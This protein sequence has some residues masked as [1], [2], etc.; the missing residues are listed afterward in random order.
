MRSRPVAG[1]RAGVFSCPQ[2][3]VSRLYCP[4]NLA[5]LP[6]GYSVS[7]SHT[8]SSPT[9]RPHR[10]A[11][12]GG[13]DFSLDP[14]LVAVAV[15]GGQVGR[16][17]RCRSPVAAG[18][19]VLIGLFGAVGLALP[20]TSPCPAL[21]LRARWPRPGGPSCW[22]RV[23]DSRLLRPQGHGDPG[24]DQYC[25]PWSAVHPVLNIAAGSAAADAR[26]WSVWP[27]SGTAHGYQP[28]GQPPARRTAAAGTC[29]ATAYATACISRG[30]WAALYRPL[31]VAASGMALTVVL[32]S[33]RDPAVQA[34]W[35]G[36][37]S[38]RRLEMAMV[39]CAGRRR[40][41]Q[42][43]PSAACRLEHRAAPNAGALRRTGA[44][45][46][47]FCPCRLVAGRR[48]VAPLSLPCSGRLV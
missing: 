39:C 20:A 43:C 32:L 42:P 9:C 35:P 19:A 28:G 1:H 24:E 18:T 22:V 34:V 3:G 30:G 2:S 13:T 40:P 47:R 29:C 4:V 33:P 31:L 12:L 38:C 21:G 46:R 10:A 8:S 36:T 44:G 48:P 45:R 27:V 25:P 23:P 26:Y 7:P 11:G 5:K 17:A 41:A 16:G 14:G 15:S 37:G 6:L